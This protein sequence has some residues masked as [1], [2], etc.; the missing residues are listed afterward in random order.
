M[1]YYFNSM[2]RDKIYSH[3][4]DLFAVNQ[5]DYMY[6]EEEYSREKRRNELGKIKILLN[7]D[8]KRRIFLNLLEKVTAQIIGKGRDRNL[9][10]LNALQYDNLIYAYLHSPLIRHKLFALKI[11][12]TF[13]LEGYDN[14]IMKLANK[15]N[16]VLHAEALVSILKLNMYDNLQFLNDYN[17]KLTV[18]DINIMAKTIKQKK[19]NDI[20]Y[21][22]LI[23]SNNAEVSALGIMLVRINKRSEFKLEVKAKISN[24]NE[25]VSEEAFLTFISFAKEQSDYDFLMYTFEIASDKAQLVIVQAIEN[26]QNTIEKI[27]FLNW[28]VEN[29]SLTVKI[30]AIRVLLDLDLNSIERFRLSKNKLIRNAILEVLDFTLQ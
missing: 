30:A 8:Y 16:N 6:A 27:K 12:S 14:Y 19:S 29:K 5:F 9:Q 22:D 1:Y 2:I 23:N 15:K 20:D 17:I 25:L 11:I 18:W 4:I 28:V 13:Q 21:L 3:S 10:L 7:S 24:I 26:Y